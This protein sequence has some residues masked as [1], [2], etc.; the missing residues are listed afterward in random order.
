MEEHLRHIARK[1]TILSDSRIG[2]RV[3]YSHTIGPVK[4]QQRLLTGS[5]QEKVNP[6]N[7]DEVLVQHE[8]FD[9]RISRTTPGMSMHLI[10]RAPEVLHL[11]PTSWSSTPSNGSAVP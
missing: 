3:C 8:L 4:R 9:E 11:P 2:W 10:V 1:A 5:P 7:L 6:V